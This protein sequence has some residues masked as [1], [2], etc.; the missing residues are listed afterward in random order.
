MELTL[1]SD[2]HNGLQICFRKLKKGVNL[3]R[4]GNH[5]CGR[6]C[7]CGCGFPVR[8]SEVCGPLATHFLGIES[9]GGIL[10]EIRAA[11]RRGWIELVID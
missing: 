7:Q 8:N 2:F 4:V 5:P 3:R 11:N 9:P 1:E 10:R 6:D